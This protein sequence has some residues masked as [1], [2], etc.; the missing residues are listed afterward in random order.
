MKDAV[1]VFG[2]GSDHQTIHTLYA[3]GTKTGKNQQAKLA[4]STTYW[5]LYWTEPLFCKN[6]KRKV[7]VKI[8][9]P[10]SSTTLREIKPPKGDMEFWNA[11]VRPPGSNWASLCCILPILPPVGQLINRFLYQIQP[12]ITRKLFIFWIRSCKC[13]PL[14]R[15]GHFT[16]LLR[17]N[18][19]DMSW[20]KMED[21]GHKSCGWVG[22]FSWAAE[23]GGRTP[24]STPV[25]DT[26]T[27]RY[28]TLPSNTQT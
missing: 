4:N 9:L 13:T 21:T 8:V 20:D 18:D 17:N 1:L 14:M 19:G 11:L 10:S 25:S 22:G 23:V 5:I 12:L 28:R 27:F 6:L 15:V 24:V 16:C 7:A 26:A 3:Y 2:G